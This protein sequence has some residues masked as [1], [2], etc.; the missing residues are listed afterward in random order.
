[1]R[2]NAKDGNNYYN[3]LLC[4]YFILCYTNECIKKRQFKIIIYYYYN[5][6]GPHFAVHLQWWSITVIRHRT[7]AI[8]VVFAQTC[9]V[10][11]T[12]RKKK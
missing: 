9:D 5:N 11:T 7:V 4:L 6:G 3:V 10:Y 2:T 8:A 12:S 1:M